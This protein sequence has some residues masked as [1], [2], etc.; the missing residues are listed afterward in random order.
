MAAFVSCKTHQMYIVCFVFHLYA[1]GTI[2][3]ISRVRTHKFS[4]D[5]L[6]VRQ[7]ETN[8]GSLLLVENRRQ[9]KALK[10]GTNTAK[11]S[12]MG[13]HKKSKQ[14]R[15]CSKATRDTC[16]L[17]IEKGSFVHL[18]KRIVEMSRDCWETIFRLSWRIG[19]L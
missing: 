19:S 5:Q 4:R 8:Y 17:E 13:H 16:V 18:A 10:L 11:K 3:E 1:R 15:R 14:Q 9:S 7:C 2:W 6:S 12:N